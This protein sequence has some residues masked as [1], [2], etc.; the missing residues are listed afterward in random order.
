ME[1]KEFYTELDELY[2]RMTSD[3]KR[4]LKERPIFQQLFSKLKPRAILD[5][6]CG[7]G[8]EALMLA[9]SGF[10]VTGVDGAERFIEIALRKAQ[11]R[12]IH[13]DFQVDDMRRLENIPDSSVDV[14]L[15]RGNTLPHLESETALRQALTA[16][17]RSLEPGGRLILQW[18][19]YPLLRKTGERLVG[20]TGDDQTIFLRFYDWDTGDDLIRFNIVVQQAEGS[21]DFSRHRRLKPSLPWHARWLETKLKPWSADDVG[22]ILAQQGWRNLEI[23]ANIDRSEFDPDISRNVVLFAV[24]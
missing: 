19:N 11:E 2:D 23:A 24:K 10:K 15:C 6:G 21:D 13:V 4:W 16:F 1:F 20:V 17:Q 3:D 22:M 7:T 18:L 12:N 9:E 8:G 14:I 5:V